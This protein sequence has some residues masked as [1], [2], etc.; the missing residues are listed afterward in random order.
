MRS[1]ILRR[2]ALIALASVLCA[3]CS[4]RSVYDGIQHQ[5]TVRNPPP[6]GQ[7]APRKPS[8]DEYDKERR[9]R[10]TLNIFRS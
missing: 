3:G 7:P 5:E 9:S 1:E 8:Y 10:I 6:Q 2:A 4:A